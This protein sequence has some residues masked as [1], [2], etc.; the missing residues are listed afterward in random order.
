MFVYSIASACPSMQAL[1][2]PTVLRKKN[3]GPRKT[4]RGEGGV[5]GGEGWR[6]RWRKKTKKI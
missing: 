6:R 3:N 4:R 2:N 1:P 5:G